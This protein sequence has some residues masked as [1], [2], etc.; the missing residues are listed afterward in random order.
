[1]RTLVCFLLIFSPVMLK[2]QQKLLTGE[3]LTNTQIAQIITDSVKKEFKLDYPIFRV[4]RYIDKSGEFLCV[5]TESNNTIDSE[6]D[7]F[8]HSIKAVDLKVVNDKFEKVWEINDNILKNHNGETSIWFWTRF[9]DFQDFDNDGLVEPIIVYGT[10][11]SS[12]YDNDRIKFIIYYKGKKIAI[13]HQ[14]GILDNERQTLVDDSFYALPQKLK[15]NIKTKMAVMVK[16][17]KA[18]FTASW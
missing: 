5:L 16:E 2:A 6:N 12:G 11:A 18:I 13:R 4:Y 1:M 17:E 7:T 8:N 9:S 15:D 14:N 10:R 3:I